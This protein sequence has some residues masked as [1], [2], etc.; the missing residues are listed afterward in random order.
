[1]GELD[2]GQGAVLL[3]RLGD[4]RHGF[5]VAILEQHRVWIRARLTAH[6]EHALFGADDAPAALRLGAAHG[7]LGLG[8][9]A[10]HAAAMGHLVEAVAAGDRA[11][12]H[13]LEENVVAIVAGHV[14]LVC[15]FIGWLILLALCRLSTVAIV[16][17]LKIFSGKS[18]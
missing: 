5:D 1:M 4:H 8:I 7:R 2:P 3:D 11:E 6:V 13:R 14:V 17:N 9:L 18:L 12:L 15:E 10:A 16:R